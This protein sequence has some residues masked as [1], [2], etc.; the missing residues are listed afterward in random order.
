MDEEF[1]PVSDDKYLRRRFEYLNDCYFNGNLNVKTIGYFDEDIA[2]FYAWELFFKKS[3]FISVNPHIKKDSYSQEEQLELDT[4]LLHEMCH[5]AADLKGED[6]SYHGPH[7]QKE[8]YRLRRK[9]FDIKA[10][11]TFNNLDKL[12][13]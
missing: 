9:G 4:L 3:Y 11:Q 13:N 1:L 7:W 10:H 2:L 5:I 8:K 12:F 6:K